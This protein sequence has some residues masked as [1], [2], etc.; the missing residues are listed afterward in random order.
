MS[1]YHIDGFRFDLASILSRD[2]QGGNNN[3]YCQDNLTSWLDWSNLDRHASM[4]EFFRTLI[5]FRKDH[6]VLRRK[7]F[8]TG[9]NSSGHPEL[10]FHGEQPWSLDEA[11]PFHTFGF[12]YA[13]TKRDHDASEDCFIYC[14]VNTYWEARSFELPIIPEGMRWHKIA[15][16]AEDAY[17]ERQIDFG[18][19]T[20]TSRSLIL[21]VGRRATC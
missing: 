8:F 14:A 12:M 13:E 7:E 15:Y 16:T 3:A 4:F 6:P 18:P 1:V 10:S 21:W 17:A 2:S 19:V 20:L 9:I 5:A 11:S